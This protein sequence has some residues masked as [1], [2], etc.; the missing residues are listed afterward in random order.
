MVDLAQDLR[1]KK[2][3]SEGRQACQI[4]TPRTAEDIPANYR[5][6]NFAI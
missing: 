2:K 6:F 5:D 1:V 4:V 3:I